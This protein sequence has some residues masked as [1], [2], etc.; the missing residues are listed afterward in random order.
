MS[1]TQK[2]QIPDDIRKTI[3]AAL[4]ETRMKPLTWT[5]WDEAHKRRTDQ[6]LK[7]LAAQ[8]H[9]ADKADSTID[10]ASTS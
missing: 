2:A 10:A 4:R 8:Q 7:W 1:D 9:K 3:E 6:A 5:L